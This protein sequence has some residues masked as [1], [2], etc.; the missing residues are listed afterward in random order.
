MSKK[1]ENIRLRLDGRWEARYVK[2]RDSSG[3]VKLGYLYGKSYERRQCRRVCCNDPSSLSFPFLRILDGSLSPKH[4]A[5]LQFFPRRFHG[6]TSAARDND[7]MG[8][9]YPAHRV[10]KR[11]SLNLNK[12][13]HRAFAAETAR[14]PH[15]FAV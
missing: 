3:K 2:S 13:I 4:T 1:G 5:T 12:I 11:Q 10:K 8:I 14:P 6:G 15:P 7:F 9:E